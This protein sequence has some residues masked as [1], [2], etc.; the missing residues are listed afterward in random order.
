MKIDFG[1]EKFLA[2]HAGEVLSGATEGLFVEI[3]VSITAQRSIFVKL[4][5]ICTKSAIQ[6]LYFL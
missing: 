2:S 3:K 1:A 6:T 4:P 5:N